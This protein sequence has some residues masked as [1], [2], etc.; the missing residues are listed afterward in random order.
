MVLKRQ[1]IAT[2]S[3]PTLGVYRH[4]GTHGT[5]R[6]EEC[7]AVVIRA[8]LPSFSCACKNDLTCSC[9][10]AG[11]RAARDGAARAEPAADGR[12]RCAARG[13]RGGADLA[14][15]GAARDGVRGDRDAQGA[16]WSCLCV[17]ALWLR[18]PS[19]RG[20]RGP[21]ACTAPVTVGYG[22]LLTSRVSPTMAECWQYCE[23]Y[24]EYSAGFR[25]G[26]TPAAIRSIRA[27]CVVVRD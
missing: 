1:S 15:V 12:R 22:A 27:R 24:R 19:E 26:Q 3:R 18:G 2:H 8:R 20:R 16:S 10:V 5:A 21:G 7:V 23:S 4:W 6:S 17:R 14:A 9:A 11:A 25:R 13:A